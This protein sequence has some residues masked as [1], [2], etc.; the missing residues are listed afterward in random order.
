MNFVSACPVRDHAQ[1]EGRIDVRH[2]GTEATR[3]TPKY[4]HDGVCC[5]VDLASPG[6]PAINQE[7]PSITFDVRRV[8]AMPLCG[9]GKGFDAELQSPRAS[10][11]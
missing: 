5:V 3:E 9:G 10:E 4:T 2:D 8:L 6:V 11:P 1:E 7:H